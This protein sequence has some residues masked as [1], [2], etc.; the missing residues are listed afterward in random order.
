MAG[1]CDGSVIILD[2]TNYNIVFQSKLFDHNIKDIR[3]LENKDIAISTNNGIFFAKVEDN[4]IQ[5][6]NQSFLQGKEIYLSNDI[7]TLEGYIVFS[8]DTDKKMCLL[9]KING[10]CI[11]LH[12]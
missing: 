2:K 8:N 5:L 9:N 6:L 11:D 3:I 10:I 7:E 4:S 1:L 12:M